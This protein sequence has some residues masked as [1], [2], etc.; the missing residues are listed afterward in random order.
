MGVVMHV[1]TLW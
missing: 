1:L